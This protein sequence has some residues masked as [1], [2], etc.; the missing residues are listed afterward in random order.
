[1]DDPRA[2][3]AG[4]VRLFRTPQSGKVVMTMDEPPLSPQEPHRESECDKARR[5]VTVVT[6]LARLA[7]IAYH[8]MRA[9]HEWI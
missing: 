8:V 9:L 1:M 2:S 3:R 7:S 4:A 5:I 6:I